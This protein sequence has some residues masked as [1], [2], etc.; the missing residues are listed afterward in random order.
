M[1]WPGRR[2]AGVAGEGG[3]RL[4]FADRREAGRVLARRLAPLGVAPSTVVLGVSRGGVPVAAEVAA[5]LG[6]ELD[7]VVAHKVG[8]PADPEFAIGAAAADGTLLVAPWA[9]EFGE[10]SLVEA[11]RAAEVE[12]ARAREREVRLRGD[13]PRL[14]LAGRPAIVVDDGIATGATLEVAARAV[15]AAGA[16]PVW[17]AAPVAAPGAAARLRPV[18]E[19]VVVLAE[20]VGFFAVGQWYREFEQLDDVEVNAILATARAAVDTGAA[21]GPRA[22][23][24]SDGRGSADGVDDRGGR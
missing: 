7:V 12:V 4:P 23:A 14:D 19:R 15:R 8:A 21:R 1:R 3:P 11:R 10:V 9:A 17:I 16:G 5:A 24:G 6:L 2:G 22:R 20:P 18:A 13:L